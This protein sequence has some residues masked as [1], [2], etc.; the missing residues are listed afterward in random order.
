MHRV[1]D[2]EGLLRWR[3]AAEAL[4]AESGTSASPKWLAR[5]E[6]DQRRQFRSANDPRCEARFGVL[7]VS[8]TALIDS[9]VDVRFGI[10]YRSPDETCFAQQG[11][12]VGVARIRF[13]QRQAIL[14]KLSTVQLD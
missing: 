13:E 6:F 8:P 11:S 1:T 7:F 14:V 9:E 5:E 2:S 12:T 4:A 3:N 10:L